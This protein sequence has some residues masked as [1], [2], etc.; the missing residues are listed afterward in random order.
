M[1]PHLFQGKGGS[2]MG[3]LGMGGMGK[4]MVFLLCD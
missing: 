3:G 2:G 1:A 4:I